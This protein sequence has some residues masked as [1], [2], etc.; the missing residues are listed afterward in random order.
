MAATWRIFD[1]RVSA[2]RDP[3][4]DQ[5][6]IRSLGRAIKASMATDMR[7]QAEEEGTEVEAMVGA[8]PHLIQEAWHHIK[9]WHEAG[10]NHA[11]PPT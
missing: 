9:G 2:R 6:L 10:V 8:D 11:P 1:K 5:T 4:R 3:E 7:R